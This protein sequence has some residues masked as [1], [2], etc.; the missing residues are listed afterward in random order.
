MPQVL[1]SLKISEVSCVDR[2]ANAE[3]DPLTGKRIPRATVALWKRDSEVPVV[4]G[5]KYLVSGKDGDH[6]PYTGADGKPD[7]SLMGAAWAA[8]HTNYRGQPYGGPDKAGAISRLSHI[9][10]QEGM[11]TPA[12][13]GDSA[14]TL[15]QIEKKLTEQDGVLATLTADNGVLKAENA[16][17]KTDA[18]IAKMGAKEKKAFGAMTAK[19]KEDYMAADADKRKSMC[20][21]FG[22]DDEAEDGDSDGSAKKIEKAERAFKAELATR[23]ERITK[24]ESE[25]KAITK[26]ARTEHFAK[27]AEAEL[28]NSPGTPVEKGQT[29]MQLADSL[30]GEEGEA[31]KRVMG[32]MKAADAALDPKFREV[33]KWGGAAN[34]PAGKQLDANAIAIS[35]RDKITVEKAYSVAMEE[36]PDL[37]L[38]YDREQRQFAR[39]Q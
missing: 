14:M 32:T 3:T 25:L 26:A 33:G 6:L 4:K 15:E 8:L 21:E 34:L 20:K 16:A 12:S 2:P 39:N 27:R 10:Q 22:T 30:G 11:D 38:Q 5:V 23:D 37:V 35:K 19:Q 17:L 13:K 1:H 28:P 36:S 24:A 29:L 9:Y 18:T 7:H 31:F